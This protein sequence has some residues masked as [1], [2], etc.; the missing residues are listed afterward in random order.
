M[1]WRASRITAT[2]AAASATLMSGEESSSLIDSPQ[3]ARSLSQ[4][5]DIQLGWPAPSVMPRVSEGTLPVETDAKNSSIQRPSAMFPGLE[6]EELAAKAS[7]SQQVCLRW[8]LSNHLHM[9]TKTDLDTEWSMTWVEERKFN[10]A[11]YGSCISNIWMLDQAAAS[12]R[13]SNPTQIKLC[14][15][16]ANLCLISFISNVRMYAYSCTSHVCYRAEFTSNEG[17]IETMLLTQ[18][19]RNLALLRV[20]LPAVRILHCSGIRLERFDDTQSVEL[21]SL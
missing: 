16:K 7:A 8:K 4:I 20:V 21:F 2:N 11:I 13:R 5:P 10:T 17:Q 19:S 1:H 9:S 15:M 12:R 14:F 18:C 3:R 6:K